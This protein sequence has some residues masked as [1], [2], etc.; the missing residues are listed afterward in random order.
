MP[1]IIPKTTSIRDLNI[2][3]TSLILIIYLDLFRNK[4]IITLVSNKDIIN[5]V[6]N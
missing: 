1:F 4:G 2:L 5:L 6:S 3:K